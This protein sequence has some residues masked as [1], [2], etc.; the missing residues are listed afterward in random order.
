MSSAMSA[1]LITALRSPDIVLAD[2]KM[3]NLL[4]NEM[5]NGKCKLSGMENEITILYPNLML[6]ITAKINLESFS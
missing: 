1:F 5:W 4:S 2:R 3:F 6:Q